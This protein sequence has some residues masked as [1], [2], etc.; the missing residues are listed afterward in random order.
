[1]PG[2]RVKRRQRKSHPDNE[3]L[4]SSKA[5]HDH[6]QIE[7]IRSF[8]RIPRKGDAAGKMRL[9]NSILLK[10]VLMAS[11]NNRRRLRCC[12]WIF[13][14]TVSVWVDLSSAQPVLTKSAFD[15]A[16]IDRERILKAANVA[17]DLEP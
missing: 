10:S 14:A 4:H 12:L 3:A 16:V 1:M 17:L 11:A 13:L 15:V 6:R 9:Q 7:T 8:T 2:P 5:F